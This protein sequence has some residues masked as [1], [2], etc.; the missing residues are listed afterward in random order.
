MYHQLR[1]GSFVRRVLLQ[2]LPFSFD[3]LNVLLVFIFFPLS[4]RTSSHRLQIR[5]AYKRGVTGH[6][7]RKRKREGGGWQTIPASYLVVS[8]LKFEFQ[9]FLFLRRRR[10]S[11]CLAGWLSPGMEPHAVLHEWR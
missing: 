6:L 3:L 2:F 11:V 8:P 9:V 10:L 4:S 5:V 7:E 1:I